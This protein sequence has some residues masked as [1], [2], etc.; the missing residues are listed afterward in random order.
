VKGN[1][2]H[3]LKRKSKRTGRRGNP[4]ETQHGPYNWFNW[5]I[6]KELTSKRELDSSE[7]D[8]QTSSSIVSYFDKLLLEKEK[9]NHS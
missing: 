8:Q 2:G 4:T 1:I 6:G 7:E 3:K 9:E 5:L